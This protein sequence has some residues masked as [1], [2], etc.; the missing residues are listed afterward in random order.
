MTLSVLYCT[1]ISNH[2]TVP[3][4]VKSVH[5][6]FVCLTHHTPLKHTA[7]R[8]LLPMSIAQYSTPHLTSPHYCSQLTKASQQRSLLQSERTDHLDI[9]T[10]PYTSPFNL[11]SSFPVTS[12]GGNNVFTMLSP[13]TTHNTILSPSCL[14]P[15][16]GSS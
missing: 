10:T 12:H 3:Q 13:L 7:T 8:S 16:T 5:V 4:T 11:I 15:P 6:H 1:K 9:L 14:A 2:R